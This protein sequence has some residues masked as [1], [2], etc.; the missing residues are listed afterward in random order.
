MSQDAYEAGDFVS[1]DQLLST[2][3]A[4]YFQVMAEKCYTINFLVEHYFMTLIQVLFELEIKSPLEL[5]KL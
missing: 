2:R 4:D 5:E 3:Q 1:A